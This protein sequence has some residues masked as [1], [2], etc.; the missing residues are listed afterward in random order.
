MHL[1]KMYIR[2]SISTLLTVDCRIIKLKP[3]SV[4][5]LAQLCVELCYWLSL[6]VLSYFIGSSWSISVLSS[7]ICSCWRLSVLSSFIDSGWSL[8][9]ITERTKEWYFFCYMI[10]KQGIQCRKAYIK[11]YDSD[12]QWYGKRNVWNVSENLLQV[13]PSTVIL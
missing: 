3:F 6:F 1:C 12:S 9:S 7:L 11:N 5:W 2:R 4:I 8:W 13:R 10:Y